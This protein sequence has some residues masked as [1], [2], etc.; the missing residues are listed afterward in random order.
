M[1][2]Y[3]V[4]QILQHRENTNGQTVYL[5]KWKNYSE[6][7]NSWETEECFL[8]AIETLNQYQ[9][10]HDLPLTVQTNNDEQ[11]ANKLNEVYPNKV[12]NYIEAFKRLQQYR[13]DHVQIKQ[14]IEKPNK[15]TNIIYIY[16]FEGHYYIIA[17]LKEKMILADGANHGTNIKEHVKKLF[18]RK[19]VITTFKQ[20]KGTDHC[21]SSAIAITLELIRLAKR[22]ELPGEQEEIRVPQGLLRNLV[23]ELHPHSTNPLNEGKGR[24]LINNQFRFKCKHCNKTC[25]SRPGLMSH[26]TKCANKEN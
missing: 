7:F 21:G 5:V 1:T 16:L 19:P 3:E 13:C 22:G 8:G 10:D 6:K 12:I 11:P 4:E 17:N 2:L 9:L 23:N 25:K 26:E 15:E 18:G 20:Q 24:V 14:L